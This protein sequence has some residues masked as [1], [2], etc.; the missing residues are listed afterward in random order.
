M[1]E[2][3]SNVPDYHD[4]HGEMGTSDN[5]AR[6]NEFFDV[7]VYDQQQPGGENIMFNVEGNND[8]PSRW[9]SQNTQFVNDPS[10]EGPSGVQDQSGGQNA[11]YF[12]QANCVVE[13]ST[14]I[15]DQPVPSLPYDCSYCHVLREI[16]HKKGASRYVV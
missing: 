3:N 12:D 8:H 10:Q 16:I 7:S 5:V 1:T 6:P 4:P 11:G 14:Q 2:P 9:E 15:L 13:N